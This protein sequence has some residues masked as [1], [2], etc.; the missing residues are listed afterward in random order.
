[1]FEGV[2]LSPAF[3]PSLVYWKE[4]ANEEEKIKFLFIHIYNYICG[5]ICK[6]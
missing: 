6:L 4:R 5:K 2:F 3:S 1:M